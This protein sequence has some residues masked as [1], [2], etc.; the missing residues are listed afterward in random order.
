[1][2]ASTLS[3]AESPSRVLAP[4]KQCPSGVVPGGPGDCRVL[5]SSGGFRSATADWGVATCTVMQTTSPQYV[6]PSPRPCG[7]WRRVTT[8]LLLLDYAERGL[9]K[10]G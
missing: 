2:G 8:R 5:C 7:S 4:G 9:Q 3:E 10:H 1:V 6:G